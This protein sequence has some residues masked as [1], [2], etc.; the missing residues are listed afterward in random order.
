MIVANGDPVT[1]LDG[2]VLRPWTVVPWPFQ[3]LGGLWCAWF[4]MD[5]LVGRRVRNR[6]AVDG[7]TTWVTPGEELARFAGQGVLVGSALAACGIVRAVWWW[8]A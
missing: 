2:F 1:L 4:A 5:L 3:I 6:P 8:A 7:R